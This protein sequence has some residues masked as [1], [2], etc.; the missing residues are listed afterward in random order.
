M[1]YELFYGTGGHGGPY[2][3]LQSAIHAAYD[4]LRGNRSEVWI[5]IHPCTGGGIGGYGES[6]AVVKKRTVSDTNVITCYDQ[7]TTI[8]NVLGAWGD[9]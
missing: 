8:E 6:I 2:Q 3:D 9:L 7:Q 5:A 4:R 1:T